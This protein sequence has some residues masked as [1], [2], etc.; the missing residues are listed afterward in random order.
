MDN[1][2]LT[3]IDGFDPDVVGVCLD[4]NHA[5]L[6]AE[7]PDVVRALG[8]RI[9]TLHISD[10]DG[11]DENHWFPFAGVIDWEP[12]VRALVRSPYDGPFMYEA[13]GVSDPEEGVE[14]LCRNYRR[15]REL[16]SAAEA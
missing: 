7:L 5:N 11:N 3:I 15:I 13:R 6:R 2:V 8:D 16:I 4:S 12:F 14:T 1:E 9:A 10:N